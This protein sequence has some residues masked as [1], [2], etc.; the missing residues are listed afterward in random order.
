[1]RQVLKIRRYTAL[2]CIHAYHLFLMLNN[3]SCVYTT[4]SSCVI[5]IVIPSLVWETK[6]AH[7]WHRGDSIV[8]LRKSFFS[9]GNFKG[10]GSFEATGES[11]AKGVVNT[12]VRTPDTYS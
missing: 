5:K 6:K 1:M 8:C 4:G 9:V 2:C 7:K 10:K 12:E 11:Y 3:Y